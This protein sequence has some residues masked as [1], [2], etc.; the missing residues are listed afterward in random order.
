MKVFAK[1]FS[2]GKVIKEQTSRYG[3]TIVKSIDIGTKGKIEVSF[4][5]RV[6][7]MSSTPEVTTIIPKVF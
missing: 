3:T 4:F 7:N 2:N 1:A 5:Y 6:S